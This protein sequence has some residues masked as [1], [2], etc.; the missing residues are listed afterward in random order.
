MAKQILMTIVFL[1]AAAPSFVFAC[2]ATE[3]EVCQYKL[4]DVCQNRFENVC[5]DENVCDPDGSNCH[6]EN[7]CNFENV[8]SCKSENVY[9]CECAPTARGGD[10]S[11]CQNFGCS[12]CDN[13]KQYCGSYNSCEGKWVTG[14]WRQCG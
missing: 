4:Q 11:F 13:R 1:F 14:D 6:L 8:Y 9:A 2:A 5:K 12:S 3:Q 7:K 10:D